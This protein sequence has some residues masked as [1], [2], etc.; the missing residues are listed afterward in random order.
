VSAK[1]EISTTNPKDILGMKKPPLR[2]I[3][4]AGLL[5]VAKVMGLG[6]TKYGPFNWRDKDVRR[7]IYLEAAMRHILSDLDGEEIDPESGQ[8]HAA[9]AASCMLI[10]M[11]AKATGNLVDDR[12]KPGATARLIA[13]LTE[14]E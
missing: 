11:D 9:H 5:H 4:P 6:A 7:S 10:L 14:K 13:E 2:L 1:E 12:P 3:P 8:P